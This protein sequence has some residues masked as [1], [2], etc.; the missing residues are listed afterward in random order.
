MNNIECV[1][2]SVG[3]D[4]TRHVLE[5]FDLR[6]HP[7]EVTALLGPNGS[8][9]STLLSTIARIHRP[10]SG[11]V[12]LDGKNIHRM[13]TR[14]VARR[15][16]LLPQGTSTPEDLR[17][18]DLV[19]YGRYPYLH[20]LTG[21]SSDDHAI[22]EKAITRTTLTSL[23][24]RPVD[25]LSGGERQRAWI[26]CALAQQTPWLLLD[27]PTTFLD[28]G[29]QVS[30]MRLLRTLHDEDGLS[31]VMVLHD[32]AQAA[33]YADRV[34]VLQ[35]G[36]IAADGTPEEVITPKI[37]REVF[38]TDA[39]VIPHPSSGRPLVIPVP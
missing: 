18:R 15:L 35:D 1:S 39:E 3:F 27:E 20:R 32:L 37:L 26:A 13:P 9:K 5:E 7:G 4:R 22:I 21:L 24:D 10:E 8:G 6:L 29:H 19:A 31:L 34:I 36:R 23:A 12:S 17:V 30:L 28:L 16:A 38:E 14:E 25:S 2:L 11:T 33:T